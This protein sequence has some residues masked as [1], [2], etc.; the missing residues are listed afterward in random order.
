MNLYGF[1]QLPVAWS[2]RPQ[3]IDSMARVQLLASS[4][5]STFE[6]EMDAAELSS[7][8]RREKILQ[9]IAEGWPTV[10]L[11]KL[12]DFNGSYTEWLDRISEL[13]A[14]GQEAIEAQDATCH[15]SQDASRPLVAGCHDSAR[16]CGTAPHLQD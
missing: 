8:E 6:G 10:D 13:T 11:G 7:P 12:K 5:K 3:P 15:G 9:A 2:G 14:S 4:H 1:A 16:C